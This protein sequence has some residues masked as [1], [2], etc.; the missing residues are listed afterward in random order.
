[1]SGPTSYRVSENVGV[2]GNT[3]KQHP[4]VRKYYFEFRRWLDTNDHIAYLSKFS[5]LP[6][7]AGWGWQVDY[8]FGAV[9]PDIPDTFP[10]IFA[11]A[12]LLMSGKTVSLMMSSGTPGISY[13]VSF[14]ATTGTGRAKQIDLVL[15]VI[16]PPA[17]MLAPETPEMPP[18]PSITIY[19]T[20]ALP[21]G[22]AGYV[23]VSNVTLMPM[24]VTL[25]PSPVLGQTL[26]IKDI[27]G[28]C[29]TYP[30]TVIGGS[31]MIEDQP[32]LVMNYNYNWVQITFTGAQWVQ[33]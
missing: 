16:P 9:L 11:D 27:A 28:N 12:A 29:G 6:G 33:V 7:Q 10:L 32:T 31:A 13:L 2:I 18:V 23:Y 15:A 17:G 25:P 4:D 14:L 5:A 19:E 24:S 20:T 30:I 26:T 21:A 3:M 22:T 8:P 1:M